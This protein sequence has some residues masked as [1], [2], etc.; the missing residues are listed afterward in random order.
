MI[1]V[2]LTWILAPLWWPYCFLR[3][4]W[5]R[6]PARI[7]V[8]E[9]AGIGDVVCS[10]AVFRALRTG[11]PHARIDLMVDP[12]VA[13][14]AATDPHIDR[15]IDFAPANLRGMRGRFDLARRFAAYD[16]AICLS[17]GAA[18]LAAMC[19]AAIPRRFSVLPDVAKLS[20]SLLRPLLSH[21]CAHRRGYPFI[22]TQLDLL[23]P[24]GIRTNDRDKRLTITPAARANA[25]SVL[26]DSGL[27]T[28]GV[29]VGSG[30]NLKE[31]PVA[32]LRALLV[33]WIKRASTRVVLLGGPLD[34]ERAKQMAEGLPQERLLDLSGRVSLAELPA[35][36]AR[37][38]AFVGVD[39][40]LTHMADALDIPLV[41]LPGPVE[42]EEQGPTGKSVILLARHPPCQPCSRVFVIPRECMIGTR[43]CVT[44]LGATE[45]IE[46]VD[47]LPS[48]P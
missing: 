15:V 18:L 36:L 45:I 3:G 26:P 33:A 46:A 28:I 14:L 6:K 44:G 24:L 30:R 19:W 7:I 2:L 17:P 12:M 41:C 31:I 23:G 34:V 22:Q 1:Y 5:R 16:T 20:Y 25:H 47:R 13:G 21:V 39:S 11:F 29:A 10:T 9:I 4:I 8:I 37:L 32:T 38:D 27:R 48:A 42:I 40:G 43:E 35:I